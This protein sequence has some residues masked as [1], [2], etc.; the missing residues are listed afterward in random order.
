MVAR[1][2][3]IYALHFSINMLDVSNQ[4]KIRFILFKKYLPR[5][6][7]RKPPIEANS[8]SVV[9]ENSSISA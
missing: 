9:D 7:A 1:D 3:Q 8:R 4:K 2:L 6:R 5:K